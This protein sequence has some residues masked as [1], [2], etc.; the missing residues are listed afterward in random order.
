MSSPPSS[1]SGNLDSHA[2][3]EEYRIRA[4][5]TTIETTQRTSNSGYSA[6]TYPQTPQFAFYQAPRA[7]LTSSTALS[8]S[9]ATP[10]SALIS[11]PVNFTQPPNHASPPRT[12]QS[13]IRSTASSTS[14]FAFRPPSE[15][16]SEPLASSRGRPPTTVLSTGSAPPNTNL[17]THWEQASPAL[18]GTSNHQ[19]HVEDEKNSEDHFPPPNSSL[20][21]FQKL[22]AVTQPLAGLGSS[23]SPHFSSLGGGL[24]YLQGP[25]HLCTTVPQEENSLYL[26]DIEE[27]SPYPEVRASV[28]NTDD[29][30]MPCVTFR[31]VL[32][33]L[34]LGFGA[35]AANMYLYLRYPAPSLSGPFP[36]VSSYVAG[37]LL[38]AIL[39]IRSWNIAGYEFSLNPG[40]FNVK[41]HTLLIMLG[42]PDV[43]YG[44]GSVI[45]WE[46]RY[47]QPLRTSF[48]FLFLISSQLLGLGL[49]GLCRRLVVYPASAIWPTNLSVAAMLNT[50]HA[51]DETSPDRKGQMRFRVFLAAIIMS[52]VW[53]F[54]PGYLFTGLSYF[55]F[56]CWIWPRN[57]IVN[58]LFGSVTGL[59][60]S[61]LTFDW[62]QISYIGSPLVL[63]FWSQIN[64][65]L[66]FVVAYWVAVPILYYSDTWKSGHLPIMG[67]SAYDRFARPYNLT[68]VFDSHTARFNVTAYEEYSPLYLPISFVITYMVAFA[69]PP[70]LLVQTILH[71]WP[72][73]NRR[74]GRSKNMEDEKEDIHAKLM[75][76]YPEVPIW[77]YLALTALCVALAVGSAFAQPDLDVPAS[78]IV[79]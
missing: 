14:N 21:S 3:V 76:H 41:E 19:S 20:S 63:P 54:V 27:D 22:E 15:P 79:L 45:A 42:L 29:P 52:C 32:I 74:L 69:V 70:A 10:T 51:G 62:G 53:V 6:Y 13:A 33:G 65:F 31:V 44:M 37:K 57:V 64:I 46:K 66:G 67:S 77:Y 55:S 28:S 61:I 49:G 47:K 58:Q 75:H 30:D 48:T 56:I 24:K 8:S 39:P 34:T 71:Y 50:L 17:Q 1:I 11:Q 18:T 2:D 78:A 38:A 26:G 40:P 12:S 36:I 5:P 25:A 72:V 7:P 9:I 60:L 59:G 23:G 16:N 4:P 35:T 73:I 43:A 68:R